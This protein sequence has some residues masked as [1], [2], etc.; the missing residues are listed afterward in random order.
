MVPIPIKIPRSGS[1][2]SPRLCPGWLYEDCVRMAESYRLP[3]TRGEVTYTISKQNHGL[4][5]AWF[6]SW[7]PQSIDHHAVIIEDDLEVIFFVL[8]IKKREYGRVWQGME[9]IYI[10]DEV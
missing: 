10:Y 2:P 7:R 3:E 8:V 5:H 9:I 4:R 6:S 1:V